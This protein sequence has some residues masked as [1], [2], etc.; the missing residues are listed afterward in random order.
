MSTL[1]RETPAT[2]GTARGHGDTFWRGITMLDATCSHDGC[3]TAPVFARGMCRSHWRA[4]RKSAGAQVKR[5]NKPRAERFWAKVDQSAGPDRCWP[6]AGPI[7][8]LRGG[9]GYFYDDDAR[10][11]RAHIVA[12]ELTHGI[13]PA[14]QVI[15]HSCDNPA[16]CN[17]AC[18]FLG[19]QG[20]NLQDMR[21]KGRHYHI[22]TS[23]SLDW[24]IAQHNAG[25]TWVDLG[26]QLGCN[27]TTFTRAIRRR[28]ERDA[29]LR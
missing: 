26:Q 1:I 13:V 7:N 21:D 4:W 16:C 20:E 27:P 19:T 15:C 2:A 28:R 5:T 25:R 3:A 10:L 29:T 22:L 6:W 11:R 18:M 12:W 8:E 24:A 14:G 23:E 17:P 9:Y